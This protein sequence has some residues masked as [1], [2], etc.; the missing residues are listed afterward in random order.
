[1]ELIQF[2]DIPAMMRDRPSRPNPKQPEVKRNPEYEYIN[3]CKK[4]GKEISRRWT[5][6]GNKTDVI[7]ALMYSFFDSAFRTTEL[8]RNLYHQKLEDLTAQIAQAYEQTGSTAKQARAD[9]ERFGS[10]LRWFIS[11]AMDKSY[12]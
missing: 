5:D 4:L 10:N 12:V 8:K 1:M 7:R 2:S 11:S 6:A 9:L 3:T